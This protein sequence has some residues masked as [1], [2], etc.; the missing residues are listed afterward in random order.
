VVGTLAE[1]VVILG[2]WTICPGGR[3]GG[4]EWRTGAWL[5][6]TSWGIWLTRARDKYYL[7]VMIDEQVSMGVGSGRLSGPVLRAVLRSVWTTDM[8]FT[9]LRL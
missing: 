1:I 3:R 8:I 2:S 4:G 5:R 7:L 9:V 6:R